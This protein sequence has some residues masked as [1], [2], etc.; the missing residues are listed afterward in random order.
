M[1]F[2]A[3]NPQPHGAIPPPWNGY[4]EPSHAGGP[5]AHPMNDQRSPPWVGAISIHPKLD[6]LCNDT[7][8]FLREMPITHD[9]S[10]PPFQLTSNIVDI[11]MRDNSNPIFPDIPAYQQSRGRA[12]RC[13]ID[14]MIPAVVHALHTY[15]NGVTAMDLTTK[16]TP[17]MKPGRISQIPTS[18]SA[19][20][21]AD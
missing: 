7:D 3:A 16:P 9:A 15:L 20:S 17:L 5:T 8:R 14:E 19:S 13:E 12:H 2:G 11:M 10:N 6:N 4:L 18:E 21:S 1:W